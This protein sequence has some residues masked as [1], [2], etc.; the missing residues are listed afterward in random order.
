MFDFHLH[1]RL[2]H[3]STADA[4]EMIAAAERL[5]LA[6]ICFTDH[7]DLAGDDPR[8]AAHL[9]TMEEYSEVYDHLPV[10]R[11]KVRLGLEFG[12]TPDSQAR[13]D[14]LVA[15]RHFDFIIGSVHS[16][17]GLGPYNPK[18]WEGRTVE[19]AFLEHLEHT[20]RC[21]RA[22]D[23][24]DVLG[25]LNYVCKAPYNPT[26][27]QLHYRDYA[28]L[29]D[30]I[31]RTLVSKGKGL[32]INTSGVDAVG[33]LLPDAPYLRRY[34]ELGGEIVTVGSDSHTVA[35]VGR[36]ID[37]ALALAREIFGYVCTFEDHRILCH[38]L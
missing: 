6:E 17:Y 21:V 16:I 26:K 4:A 30:E 18:F 10:S 38:K 13:A 32:E 23:T 27:K 22:N 19:A 35:R 29:V 15:A 28:D 1:S 24:F 3:D 36:N 5:G 37:L 7:Y 31:L 14:A 34:R 20:L 2:S 11:V 33:M 8:V 12:L 9:L 25:H